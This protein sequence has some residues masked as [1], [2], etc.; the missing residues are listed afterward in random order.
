MGLR[1]LL[2]SMLDKDPS[3]RP[4]VQQ[5]VNHQYFSYTSGSLFE[6]YLW[7]W[8]MNG[9][10][11]LLRRRY[12]VVRRD[13]D[14]GTLTY[15]KTNEKAECHAGH[16][17]GLGHLRLGNTVRWST[18]RLSLGLRLRLDW[19]AGGARGDYLII[20]SGNRRHLGELR[21]AVEAVGVVQRQ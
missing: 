6:G 16:P 19:T 8:P 12:F 4:T 10:R 3:K 20:Q 2:A 9:Q 15:Y 7:K 14:A 5:L 13:G 21:Q 18:P 11:G 1:C 17:M